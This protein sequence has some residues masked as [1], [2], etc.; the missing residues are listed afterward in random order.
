FPP[1]ALWLDKLPPWP[2]R[3]S[4]LDGFPV[5][6]SVKDVTELLGSVG[7]SSP[8]AWLRP[9]HVLST[10]QRFRC[11]LA[12]LL[13]SASPE[14]TVVC[15]EFTGVVGRSIARVG[16]PAVAKAVRSRK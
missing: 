16:R 1:P 13:A 6:F 9:Y 3:Q 2:E 12:R 11:G 5:G 8:P 15:D 7:F 10:G 14:P 4:V